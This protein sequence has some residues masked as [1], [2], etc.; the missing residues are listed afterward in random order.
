M[1]EDGRMAQEGGIGELGQGAVL[2]VPNKKV[3]PNL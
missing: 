3:S 2:F 1:F